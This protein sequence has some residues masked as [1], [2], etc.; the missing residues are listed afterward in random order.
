MRSN[1][2]RRVSR[3]AGEGSA[4]EEEEDVMLGSTRDVGARFRRKTEA[5]L[6]FQLVEDAR[7]DSKVINNFH[8]HSR[9]CCGQPENRQCCRDFMPRKPHAEVAPAIDRCPPATA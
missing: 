8:T 7:A 3:S 9:L 2:C 6:R 5:A 4:R 1:C